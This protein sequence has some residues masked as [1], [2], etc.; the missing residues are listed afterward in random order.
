[1]DDSGACLA[2]RDPFLNQPPNTTPGTSSAALASMCKAQLKVLLLTEKQVLPPARQPCSGS[3]FRASAPPGVPDRHRP[4]VVPVA[5]A[6][7]FLALGPAMALGPRTVSVHAA[8]P[9]RPRPPTV[10][11][12]SGISPSFKTA[13][14]QHLSYDFPSALVS[15]EYLDAEGLWLPL[16]TVITTGSVRGL[17]LSSP[18][19]YSNEPVQITVWSLTSV[20]SNMAFVPPG[21]FRMGDC[22]AEG[23]AAERPVRTVYVSAFYIDKYEVTN[24]QMRRVLQWA[25]D[26]GLIGADSTTVTNREGIPRQLLDLALRSDGWRAL[27][28][29]AF[30]NGKFVV[31]GGREDHPVVNVTWYGAQAYCNYRSDMEGLSR[32]IN[33][34]DWSCDFEKCGYR[35]PTEAEWE[36]AARG[37]MTGQQ[38]PWVSFGYGYTNYINETMAAY[39]YN[40]HPWK[41]PSPIVEVTNFF[42]ATTPVGYW[43]GSQVV[44]GVKRETNVVN[45]YGLYDM[46]GN[47]WEWVYDAFDSGWYSSAEACR[48]DPTG[49]RVPVEKMN[50]VPRGF[51]GGSWGNLPFYLRVACRDEG[52]PDGRRP[53]FK[54]YTQ[55]FRCVRR[56]CRLGR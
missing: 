10:T 31:V 51:R 1:M 20:P 56:P 45:G 8:S 50:V 21:Y 30:T 22:W 34:A 14:I 40:W 48:P 13:N 19:N 3:N 2:F 37:G 17:N 16:T 53:D 49:P 7:L 38:F 15:V 43:S 18:P 47:V 46:A 55:G 28:C 25:Y 33:F 5:L 26:R 11:L 24:E 41:L 35:L 29:I 44:R 39:F 23:H 9:D 12:I 4:S 27:G 32:C 52:E 36:K 6:A 54:Q 42:P